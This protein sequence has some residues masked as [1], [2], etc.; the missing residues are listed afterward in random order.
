MKYALLISGQ[1]RNVKE[2]YEGIYTKV[3][4]PNGIKDIFIHSWIDPD[5]VGKQY[6]AQWRRKLL[7][8]QQNEEA[9]ERSVASKVVPSNIDSTI[10]ELYNP[11]VWKFEKPKTFS[12]DTSVEEYLSDVLYVAS[13]SS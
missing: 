2:A 5:M 9:E 10:L 7:K 1:P 8:Q 13:K 3:I 12:Y 11:K 4:E 6:V